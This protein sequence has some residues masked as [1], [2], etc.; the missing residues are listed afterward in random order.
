[1]L[2]EPVTLIVGGWLAALGWALAGAAANDKATKA[3][4]I[5]RS[6][7][8]LPRACKCDATNEMT[9]HLRGAARRCNVFP[10]NAALPSWVPRLFSGFSKNEPAEDFVSGRRTRGQRLKEGQTLH[11]QAVGLSETRQ[12]QPP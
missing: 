7:A 1:M 6:M 2:P 5:W 11:D 12:R 4:A 9:L 3:I 10:S 8:V